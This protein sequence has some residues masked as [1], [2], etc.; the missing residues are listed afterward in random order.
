MN[1][2][3]LEKRL[4]REIA[5][6]QKEKVLL[7]FNLAKVKEL[8]YKG[9]EFEEYFKRVIDCDFFIKSQI[10][11]IIAIKSTQKYRKRR[12]FKYKLFLKEGNIC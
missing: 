9:K 4:E 11:L 5:R 12:L 8:Q 6:L 1:I 2:I 7:D 10:A 3:E